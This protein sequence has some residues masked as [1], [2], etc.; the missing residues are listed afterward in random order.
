MATKKHLTLKD[1]INI[2]S[3]LDKGLKFYEIAILLGKDKCTVSKEVRKHLTIKKSGAG[4]Q[5]YNPCANAGKCM[6]FNACPTDKPF[7]GRC[8]VCGKCIDYCKDFV[9]YECPRLLLPP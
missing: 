7:C 1:R 6:K 2:Q 8:C 3:G 9:Y 4:G 5:K